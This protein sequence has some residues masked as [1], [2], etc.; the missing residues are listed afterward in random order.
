MKLW[1][2]IGHLLYRLSWPIINLLPVKNSRVRCLVVN[3]DEIFLTKNWFGSNL[4]RLPGGG[5]KRDET[6]EET[7][8]RELHE[9]F[10]VKPSQIEATLIGR[11]SHRRTKLRLSIPIVLVKL[12]MKP[13]EALRPTSRSISQAKWFRLDRLPKDISEVT[14][15]AIALLQ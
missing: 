5:V 10:E 4:W 6:P 14:E 3:G 8:V 15:R 11:L 12:K 13:P 7:A 9:E 1:N 2:F